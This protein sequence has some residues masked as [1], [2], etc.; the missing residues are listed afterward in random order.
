MRGVCWQG[1]RL[2]IHENARKA[3]FTPIQQEWKDILTFSSIL[4]ICSRR[5]RNKGKQQER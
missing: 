3:A 4:H 1:G 2:K 5:V